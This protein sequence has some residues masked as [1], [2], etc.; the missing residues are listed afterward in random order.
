MREDLLGSFRELSSGWRIAGSLALVAALAAVV[1]SQRWQMLLKKE[2]S[3]VWWASNG[4][5]VLNAAALVLLTAALWLIG[6]SVGAGLLFAGT[7]VLVMHLVENATAERRGAA[8][9]NLLVALALAVPL[10]AFPRQTQ[11]LAN[12]VAAR[13]FESVALGTGE[14]SVE[15]TRVPHGGQTGRDAQQDRGDE[16][17]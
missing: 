7:I 10:L 16:T 9:V 2:E 11:A 12:G 1:A 13:L 6:F 4:R 17:L 3:S 15:R 5:D 14:L 8:P